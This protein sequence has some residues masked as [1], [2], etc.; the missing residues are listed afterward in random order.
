MRRTDTNKDSELEFM[1]VKQEQKRDTLDRLLAF[2]FRIWWESIVLG[3]RDG[4]IE[5]IV[6]IRKRI[7]MV[8]LSAHSN[9][10]ASLEI[11]NFCVYIMHDLIDSDNTKESIKY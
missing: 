7:W 3:G 4:G 2:T 9:V 1:F 5:Y 10:I 11:N 6:R 8:M